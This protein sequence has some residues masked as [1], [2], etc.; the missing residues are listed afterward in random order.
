M[1]QR[2]L[3][4]AGRVGPA[5]RL[6]TAFVL[7]IASFA[8]VP[9]GLRGEEFSARLYL[10]CSMRAR[11][12]TC[13]VH[14]LCCAPCMHA[15]RACRAPPAVAA[16]AL[17]GHVHA[18]THTHRR[19][20]LFGALKCPL[21]AH[22]SARPP[23]ALQVHVARCGGAQSSRIPI[24]HGSWIPPLSGPHLGAHAG[25]K[26]GAAQHGA[27][28]RGTGAMCAG[29]A[30]QHVTAWRSA[31]VLLRREGH[32]WQQRS[33]SGW[34]CLPAT[35]IRARGAPFSPPSPVTY[36]TRS[37]SR[38]PL[39][40]LP[41]SI[42]PHLTHPTQSSYPPQVEAAGLS[43]QLLSGDYTLAAQQLS[44][45]LFEGASVGDQ[46]AGTLLELPFA[47]MPGVQFRWGVGFGGWARG[48]G[49]GGRG[50]GWTQTRC[51]AHKSGSHAHSPAGGNQCCSWFSVAVY[52]WPLPCSSRAQ[53]GLDT[54]RNRVGRLATHPWLM[55][56]G[57]PKLWRRLPHRLKLGWKLPKGRAPEQH[58]LF[59][60]V[61]LGAGQ[62][63]PPVSVGGPPPRL[64][65]PATPRR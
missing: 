27:A 14:L 10:L 20:L 38:P 53:T 13:A 43:G 18:R 41:T 54:S 5:P 15:C 56:A 4:S 21:H 46:P 45:T 60:H 35:C 40:S 58:H 31:A 52:F 50:Q 44:A 33:A 25:A 6:C 16:A 17:P 34:A 26:R 62:L 57:S 29:S 63:Q 48:E 9:G 12:I 23:A 36:L 55:P 2:A 30:A 3:C 49:L 24:L 65:T 8:Q 37:T 59:P 19:Q 28:Q 7:P 1:A 22:S 64:C 39:P 32:A 11:G 51:T 42:P 47:R 61:P